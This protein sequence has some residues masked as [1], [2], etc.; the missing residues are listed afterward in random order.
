MCPCICPS[1]APGTAG[2]AS[3]TIAEAVSAPRN[4]SSV[5][6]SCRLCLFLFPIILPCQAQTYADLCHIVPELLITVLQIL[7][8]I[9]GEPVPL[10]LTFYPCCVQVLADLCPVVA[11]LLI[12][13]LQILLI[14]HHF[15]H[16]FPFCVIYPFRMQ[17][18]AD[19]CHVVCQLLILIWQ[20]LLIRCTSSVSFPL[21]FNFIPVVRKE[22]CADF[23]MLFQ[24]SSSQFG[25]YFSSDACLFFP[26]L[27]PI[28]LILPL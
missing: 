3:G 12:L 1:A 7:L 27:S 19:L 2:C 18:H 10:P 5:V 15:P 17:V 24:N 23:F 6:S 9:K 28:F 20:T 13:V 8:L 14:M 4:F 22:V 16:L 26:S 11:E 21:L 25:R